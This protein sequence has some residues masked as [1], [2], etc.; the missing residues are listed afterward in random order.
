MSDIQTPNSFVNMTRSIFESGGGGS[1]HR[2]LGRERPFPLFSIDSKFVEYSRFLLL[3]IRTNIVP[4]DWLTIT[5]SNNL[6]SRFF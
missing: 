3:F 5:E 6:L 2:G 1:K 4:F